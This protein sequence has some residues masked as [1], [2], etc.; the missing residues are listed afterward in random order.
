M[1]S[2]CAISMTAKTRSSS[3]PWSRAASASSSWIA[4][5]RKS[6]SDAWAT[7]SIIRA[8]ARSIGCSP[9]TDSASASDATAD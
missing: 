8:R 4:P 1:L 9:S 3:G 5:E 7:P 2:A 6:P